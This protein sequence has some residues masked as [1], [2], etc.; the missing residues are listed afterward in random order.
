M[1]YGAAPVAPQHAGGMRVVN[2]HDA[3]VL[4]RQVDQRR[5]R[6]NIAVHREHAVGDEQ[7][8]AAVVL[9]LFEDGL[10]RLD[11]LVGED[12]DLGAREAAAVDDGG[13]VELV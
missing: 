5:Q 4:F 13:V 6:R 12:P 7:L 11:V 3:A 10:A 8:A 9:N 2:H 1:V